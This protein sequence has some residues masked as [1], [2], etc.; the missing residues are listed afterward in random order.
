MQGTNDLISDRQWLQW[1]DM[2]SQTGQEVSR[3][4]EAKEI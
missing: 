1:G 3:P 2:R 4:K